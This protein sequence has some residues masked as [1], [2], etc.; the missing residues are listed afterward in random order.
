MRRSA[1]KGRTALAVLLALVAVLGLSATV[2]AATGHVAVQKINGEYCVDVITKEET[3]DG[4]FTQTVVRKWIPE[5]RYNP[6]DPATPY[7]SSGCPAPNPGQNTDRTQALRNAG[8][9][10]RN[11]LQTYGWDYQWSTTPVETYAT[12]DKL[13]TNITFEVDASASADRWRCSFDQVV[14]WN[15]NY[16]VVRYYIDGQEYTPD[17]IKTMFRQYG[18]K[19]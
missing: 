19:R 14:T 2:Y 11:D 18:T 13:V 17:S 15:G 7:P 12:S 4:I 8:I 6:N 16:P 5:N 1:K 10:S 3:I 9:N